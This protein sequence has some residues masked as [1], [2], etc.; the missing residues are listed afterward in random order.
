MKALWLCLGSRTLL[1]WHSAYAASAL[2]ESPV[3]S[4]FPPNKA[5]INV[6]LRPSLELF[7]FLLHKRFFSIGAQSHW[8]LHLLRLSIITNAVAELLGGKNQQYLW[9]FFGMI[10]KSDKREQFTELTDLIS[11]RNCSCMYERRSCGYLGF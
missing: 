5:T 4:F 8:R 2:L 3:D 11:H 7:G 9:F 10:A 6:W 1:C